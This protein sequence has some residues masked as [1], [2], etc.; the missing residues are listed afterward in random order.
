MDFSNAVNA[1][2][3]LVLASGIV[4]NI[5]SLVVI[6]MVIKSDVRSLR[7]G[8]TVLAIRMDK[9]ETALTGQTAI[10]LKQTKQEAEIEFLKDQIES[11]NKSLGQQSLVR[12]IGSNV[13]QH[14]RPRS[15]GEQTHGDDR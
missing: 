7:E 9:M 3:L 2:Q 5:V 12:Y 6:I 14:A 15:E 4:T 13:P 1:G 11:L 8:Q 10:M